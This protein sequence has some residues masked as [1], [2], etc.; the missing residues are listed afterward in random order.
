MTRRKTLNLTADLLEDILQLKDGMLI[1]GVELNPSNRSIKLT[2]E[3]ETFDE[4][5]D[6]VEPESV[7]V[8]TDV[9]K[10]AEKKSSL[11]LAH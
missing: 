11:I 5:S 3:S 7:K 6:G 4:V 1:R 10:Q 2:I 9:I 8:I